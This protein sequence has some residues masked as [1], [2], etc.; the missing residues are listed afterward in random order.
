[1]RRTT[2]RSLFQCVKGRTHLRGATY[3]L[4][5][6]DKRCYATSSEVSKVD[7][8]APL[9]PFAH[10]HNLQPEDS[11][12]KDML[13]VIGSQYK[14]LETLVKAI[15]PSDIYNGD[16]V[17][18]LSS[19]DNGW[20]HVGEQ[21]ALK[22]LKEKFANKNQVL[23]SLIG[24]GYY[25][26]YTPGVVLRNM[27][28]NPGWYTQYTPYQAEI[29][30]GR[31]ESLLNFQTMV[32]DLTALPISNASLL[33]EAT[34][35]AE[36]MN[37]CFNKTQRNTFFV[38]HKVS[39]QTIDVVKTRAIPLG[40]EVVVGDAKTF[41]LNDQ[42]SGVL[43]QYPNVDGVAIDYK[44]FFKQAKQNGSISVC[45][46]D[47]LALCI[48]TPPG[49]LGADVCVG[50]TQRFGVPLGYG[51]PHAAFMSVQDELKR[52]IPGRLIG[53]SKDAQGNVA[54]RMSLQTREQHIRRDKATSNICTAQALLANC[55]AM[56]AIYHGPEGLKKI[57]STVHS[58][59]AYLRQIIST[60]YQ[61]QDEKETYFDTFVIKSDQAKQLSDR[62][63]QAGFNLRLIDD[64]RVGIS[65]D[66]TIEQSDVETLVRDV[67]QLEFKTN[68]PINHDTLT[69]SSLARTSDFLSHPVFNTYH[70]EHELLRYIW[71]LQ[72]RDISLCQSMIPLG[73]CT[74]KLNSSSE[75]IPIT[76][77]QFNNIHPFAPTAQTQGYLDLFAQLE[78]WLAIITGFDA[79]SLQPNAGSQGEFTGLLSI[80]KYLEHSGQLNRNICLIPTSAHGTNPAS[81]VMAGM[82]VVVVKCDDKG[83]IDMNDLSQKANQ[84]K[85]TLA[86]AMVTYP[87]TH[88]VY[89]KGI[90]E[91]C[92]VVHSHG[93]QVYMDGANMNAQVGLTSPGAI[94]ADVCHLNLHKTFCIPHGGGGPGM[95]PIGVKS[96]LAPFLPN[97][98]CVE[99]PGRSDETSMGAV[100]AAPWSSSSILAI[101]WMYIR[102]MGSVGLRTATQVAIM[103]ANY[104]A[105]RLESHY[106]IVY[107]G[108]DNLVAHEFIIDLNKINKTCGIGAEDV[109]KRLMDYGFHAP[110]MSFPIAGTLMIEPT[111]SESR[112]ELDRFC[113]ALISIRREI[114]KVENGE[115]DRLDN[116]LKNAPHTLQV[117]TAED[118]NHKYSRQVA[119]FPTRWTREVFKFWPT[120]A[121]IDSAFGDKNLICTCPPL[122]SY[123]SEPVLVAK[124]DG[125]NMSQVAKVKENS[126]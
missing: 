99:M 20:T 74:M 119:A 25:N 83:N 103:N 81:A 16:K 96:H 125:E 118:W 6:K 17:M 51:G 116:P 12:T 22:E 104:M 110:T 56:Y 19:D 109:A 86:C 111:E 21:G 39:P 49:E 9:D 88:G 72:S 33:D 65:L 18:S 66:E 8:F 77:P 114:E 7:P 46:S 1:M 55:A 50:N 61:I 5:L 35:A 10:R 90:A 67:F 26:T 47:L 59:T 24:M 27:V 101:S 57:A 43:V 68:Q 36:A 122:D 121:R 64:Q 76:W 91:L 58:R 48:L 92:D 42:V 3:G 40:I 87:S 23:K 120:V 79:V 28:E 124:G 123:S 37:I 38:D 93:G 84:Y 108:S 62:A 113:D 97:H 89:E 4:N 94:G 85:D 75:M 126:Y 31:L 71:R 63:V 11:E 34:A 13:N 100:S 102:M 44:D 30:Q 117:V 115:Y 98:S 14:D 73:S 41:K 112:Q 45:A 78:R 82:K 29:S 95:G 107:R 80:K 69:N 52:S 53:V 70:T 106:K 15:I 2:T 105:K 60:K 32:S 54:Y